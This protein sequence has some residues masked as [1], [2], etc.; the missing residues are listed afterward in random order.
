[1]A[2]RDISSNSYD[3]DVEAI[4]ILLYGA[5]GSGKTWF[6]G[7]M[8]DVYIVSLD[9]GLK[10][11][12]LAGM[13][14]DG[15]EVDTLDELY[16]VIDEI[17]RGNRGKGAKAF[18]LD[19]LTEVTELAINHTGLRSKPN[20]HKRAVWG[21]IADH[22]RMVTRKFVDIAAVRKVPVCVTAHQ[23]IDKNE[24]S[25]NILGLPS[26]VGKLAETVGGFFDMYLYA[27]S[28]VVPKDGDWIPEWTVST[29]NYREFSAKDRTGT[30]DITE[31]NNFPT[32]MNKVRERLEQVKKGEYNA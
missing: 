31:P 24:L 17:I 12:R 22:A 11:L 6:I 14:F 10:G 3:F 5:P 18:A 13:Q 27:R 21:E 32:I 19:H 16:Q 7:T 15:C 28:D 1:M 30:L 20:S 25:G 4:T 26:T 23:Q 9:K 2:V 29:V 8:P